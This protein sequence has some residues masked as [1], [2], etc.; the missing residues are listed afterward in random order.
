MGEALG[1]IV[2]VNVGL[3]RTVEWH[4]R[5][6]TSAIWRLPVD[7]PVEIIGERGVRGFSLAARG[8]VMLLLDEG[9]AREQRPSSSPPNEPP[10]RP[11]P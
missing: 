11:S 7:G 6:M 5:Q 2:S 4:G 1:R 3:P 9:P 10:G 8:H